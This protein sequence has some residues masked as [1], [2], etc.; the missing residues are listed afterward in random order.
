MQD[1][2]V[3]ILFAEYSASANARYNGV[4]SWWRFPDK[5]DD[6]YSFFSNTYTNNVDN[7]IAQSR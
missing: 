2:E 4:K 5:I 7:D 1:V 6:C 3:E